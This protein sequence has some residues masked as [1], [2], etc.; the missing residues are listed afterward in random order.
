MFKYHLLMSQTHLITTK[1]LTRSFRCPEQ[2]Q[3]M[4]FPSLQK[5]RT[6]L[7]AVNDAASILVNHRKGGNRPSDESDGES[8][9]PRQRCSKR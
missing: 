8:S 1:L 4:K 7:V 2:S 9:S 5:L 6:T 3:T